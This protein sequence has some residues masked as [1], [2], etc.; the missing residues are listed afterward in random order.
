MGEAAAQR[1]DQRSRPRRH[2]V[3]RAS[4]S[5]G[6]PAHRSGCARPAACASVASG[7]SVRSS[8]RLERLRTRRSRTSNSGFSHTETPR[9]AT[10]RRVSSL[11][12]APPPVDSTL[13]PSLEQTG[14]HPALAVAKIGFAEP[15]EDFGDRHLRAG[16]DLVVGV[17]ERQAELV[18]EALADRGLAGPHHADQ[19]DRPAAQRGDQPFG[20]GYRGRRR[21]SA[22]FRAARRLCRRRAPLISPIERGW[23][24][25]A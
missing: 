1:A 16:L 13:G 18:G 5:S 2:A 21:S 7:S 6:R 8:G 10:R 22:L 24:I 20:L 3:R 25:P 4:R 14:D 9:S 17:D 11:R 12:K 23:P 19:H 15:L